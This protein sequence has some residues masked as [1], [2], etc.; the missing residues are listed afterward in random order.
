MKFRPKPYVLFLT[1]LGSGIALLFLIS[2][3]YYPIA[4]VERQ[5]VTAREFREG[6]RFASAYSESFAKTYGAAASSTLRQYEDLD[7]VQ[8]DVLTQLIENAIIEESLKQ[9][10]GE[11]YDGLISQKVE[12]YNKDST[13]Q[14]A[15]QSLFGVEYSAFQQAVL[16]PQARREIMNGRLFLKGEKFDEWMERVKKDANISIFSGKFR[17]DGSN[18]TTD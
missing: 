16:L 3:G 2:A 6:Y 8:T 11:E 12:K 18:V 17:W 1:F 10:V 4:M 14:A 9:E 5:F 15:A 7:A 13:L